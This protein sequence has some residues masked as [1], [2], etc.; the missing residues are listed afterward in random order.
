MKGTRVLLG[1]HSDAWADSPEYATIAISPE[2][3]R[4]LL[5]SICLAARLHTE[6]DVFCVEWW[7]ASP[8]WY[9]GMPDAT[10]E[11]KDQI[12]ET[13]DSEGCYVLDGQILEEAESPSSVTMKVDGKGVWWAGYYGSIR[14]C[15]T[16]IP[17][18]FLQ[19]IAGGEE[20]EAT[21]EAAE[22]SDLCHTVCPYCGTEMGEPNVYPDQGGYSEAE[23]QCPDCRSVVLVKNI[24]SPEA[25]WGGMTK[26][27]ETEEV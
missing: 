22:R 11:L 24:P 8:A 2:Y 21:F 23:Y 10:S 27:L 5:E 3:A 17:K 6:H 14:C 25:R 16:I 7:D 26:V 20:S 1:V 13:L 12:T 9:S 15:T 18:K 4:S 19:K